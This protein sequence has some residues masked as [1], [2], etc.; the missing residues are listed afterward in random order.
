MVHRIGN[1][2]KTEDGLIGSLCRW[3]HEGK[4]YA[5]LITIG[6]ANANDSFLYMGNRYSDPVVVKDSNAITSEEMNLI[7][8][9]MKYHKYTAPVTI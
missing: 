8:H 2:Y 3:L 1:K 5:T 4:E 7:A 6:S 9:G